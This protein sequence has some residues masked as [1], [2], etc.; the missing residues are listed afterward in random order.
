MKKDKIKHMGSLPLEDDDNSK[1]SKKHS[2]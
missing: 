1:N 2:S